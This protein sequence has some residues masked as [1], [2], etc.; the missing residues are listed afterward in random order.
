MIVS[1]ESSFCYVIGN[2]AIDILC[3]F[4]N[5]FIQKSKFSIKIW[6]WHKRFG[7]FFVMST[8]FRWNIVRYGYWKFETL[9]TDI[10]AASILKIL[11]NNW[12]LKIVIDWRNGSILI[13]AFTYIFDKYLGCDPPAPTSNSN[14]QQISIDYFVVPNR[15]KQ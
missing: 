12:R 7:S 13:K 14:Y 10:R 15:E 3:Q 6:I 4:K 9:H 1:G 8:S 2:S 5:I 11:Q